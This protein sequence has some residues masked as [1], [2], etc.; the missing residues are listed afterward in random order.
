MAYSLRPASAPS[1]IRT[2][3]R[4]ATP[5]DSAGM[6]SSAIDGCNPDRALSW[7][8]CS[9]SSRM[10]QTPVQGCLGSRSANDSTT[11]VAIGTEGI[12]CQRTNHRHPARR[13][14]QWP[15]PAPDSLSGAF[16]ATS[17]AQMVNIMH[18]TV[19]P[20]A[21][22]SAPRPHAEDDYWGNERARITLVETIPNESLTDG[23]GLFSVTLD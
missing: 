16:V 6:W 20:I 7:Q 3:V 22:V 9:K 18:F 11:T 10:R 12:G 17:T 19:N 15:G 13:P 14:C 4:G 2:T 21:F 8:R 1:R 5:A 23:E